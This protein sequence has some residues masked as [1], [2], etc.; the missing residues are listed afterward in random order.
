LPEAENELDRTYVVPLAPAW[1]APRYRRTSRAVNV[2][3][4]FAK[5]HMKSSEIK[6]DTKLNDTL[7]NRGITKPPRRITVRMTK[8]EDGLVTI[9]LPKAQKEEDEVTPAA[10]TEVENVAGAEKG[11]KAETSDKKEEKTTK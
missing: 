8:D 3:K 11:E 10:K 5:R 9:S 1:I 7:W 4:E 2:L 6:I